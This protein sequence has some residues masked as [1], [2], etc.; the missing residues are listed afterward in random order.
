MT[1]VGSLAVAFVIK[2]LLTVITFG[3]KR[4]LAP[5]SARLP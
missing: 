1:V 4:R 5:T 2:A 3:I